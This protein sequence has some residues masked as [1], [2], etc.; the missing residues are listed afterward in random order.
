M[1]TSRRNQPGEASRSV[2]QVAARL[3]LQEGGG[4]GGGAATAAAAA[5]EAGGRG[6]RGPGG[7]H[8][9]FTSM[10]S[11]MQHQEWAGRSKIPGWCSASLG[12]LAIAGGGARGDQAGARG[13]GVCG[14]SG[15][16]ASPRGRRRAALAA[17]A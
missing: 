4:G 10:A 13:A 9:S 15:A 5:D 16:T 12:G 8:L 2:L 7:P 14:A 11:A 17:A 3:S 1:I 6:G